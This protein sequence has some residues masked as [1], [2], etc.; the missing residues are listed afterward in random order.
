MVSKI[1]QTF[2][3]DF[4]IV[5]TILTSFIKCNI[6]AS[7]FVASVHFPDL[8]F[9]EEFQQSLRGNYGEGYEWR[10]AFESL[11]CV[12]YSVQVVSIGLALQKFKTITSLYDARLDLHSFYVDLE[13]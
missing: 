4:I 12:M 3:V 11:V 10:N 2:C 1:F 9:S 7:T 6:G 13:F 8:E 5:L